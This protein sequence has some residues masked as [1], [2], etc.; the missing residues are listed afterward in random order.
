MEQDVVK[1]NNKWLQRYYI[2]KQNQAIAQ[3]ELWDDP[4]GYYFCNIVTVLPDQ[5]GKGIGK[6]LFKAVTDQA[7]KEGRKCYL[8]SS[9]DKP[10]TLIYEKMGFRKVKKMECNDDGAICKVCD[11][12]V[13]RLRRH[14][15]RLF[16]ALLHD[17]RSTTWIGFRNMTARQKKAYCM[18]LSRLNKIYLSVMDN[19]VFGLH[20]S[21][22]A[23]PTDQMLGCLLHFGQ[24]GQAQNRQNLGPESSLGLSPK[25]DFLRSDWGHPTACG[26]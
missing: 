15:N 5:Q 8:E 24:A 13:P 6:M 18:C 9:R 16:A 10:N 21:S 26:R 3:K 12:L 1:R 25:S 11:N 7:D 17:S 14:S 23:M 22:L 19:S 2:W 4:H 20:V